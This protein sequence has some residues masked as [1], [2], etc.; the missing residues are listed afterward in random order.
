M[1]ILQVVGFAF[2]ALFMAQT[3]KHNRSDIALLISTAA[4]IIIFLFVISKLTIVIS[5]LQTI[6]NKANID[7]VY[8][9]IIFKILA[10][11]Y[12][13]SFCS[14]VCKDAG[15]G[16]IAS[17]V[18]FAGKILIL[19]LAMPILMGVMQTILKML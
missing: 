16:S 1:E 10:I 2:A 19:T 9:D 14:E 5:F 15:E 8:L 17:K 4:G 3:L 13:A 11:A 7:V 12:L 6:A 18:E